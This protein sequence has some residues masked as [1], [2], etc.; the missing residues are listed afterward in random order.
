MSQAIARV[1]HTT[2]AWVHS[3]SPKIELVKQVAKRSFAELAICLSLGCAISLFVAPALV[4]YLFTYILLQCLFS[5]AIR[6]VEAVMT[7]K[8]TMTPEKALTCRMLRTGS[9]SAVTGPLTQTLVHEMGH[10]TAANRCFDHA[11]PKIRIFPFLGGST[12][13]DTHELSRFGKWLGAT[14]AVVFVTAAGAALTLLVSSIL[15]WLSQK[16]RNT[17][18]ETSAYL[19]SYSSNDFLMHGYYALSATW[20]NPTDFSHDFVRLA[21][22]T[23]LS[24][25]TMLVTIVAIP[26]LIYAATA[27][28]RK[29]PQDLPHPIL[30]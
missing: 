29:T 5:S 12:S 25:V 15:F 6:T 3:P 10:A 27:H 26:A 14:G 28:Y 22:L 2:P 4:G 18:P 13:F 9:F 7:Y 30:T 20:A 17:H 8:K 11:N 23:G 24:P 19:F 1:G 16:L 21:A